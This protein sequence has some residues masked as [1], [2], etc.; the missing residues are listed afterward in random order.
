MNL[1]SNKFKFLIKYLQLKTLAFFW[2]I[3]I[4]H[5]VNEIETNKKIRTKFTKLK[6]T[7]L[8]SRR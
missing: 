6:R 8:K 2:G 1:F 7:N 4:W 5:K 3:L